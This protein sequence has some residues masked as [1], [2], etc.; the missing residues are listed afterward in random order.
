MTSP[1]NTYSTFDSCG[2]FLSYNEN[3]REEAEEGRISKADDSYYYY[4]Y[5]I[6]DKYL[7]EESPP[8]L[9]LLLLVV[10]YRRPI[11]ADLIPLVAVSQ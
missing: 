1:K 10:L 7:L 6:S 9:G 2:L 8:L 3:K 11:V 5:D 4:S